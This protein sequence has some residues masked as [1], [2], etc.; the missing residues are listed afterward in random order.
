MIHLIEV[1]PNEYESFSNYI[2]TKD[3]TIYAKND[4]VIISMEGF[5]E[6]K[7]FIIV[8][9]GYRV[10]GF[11]SLHLSPYPPAPWLTV[12]DDIPGTVGGGFNDSEGEE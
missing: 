3:K 6:Q 9:I 7:E 5:R 4:K 11:C 1:S 8:D 2:V 10:M 12:Y